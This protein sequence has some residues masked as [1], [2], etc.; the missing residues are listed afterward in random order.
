MCLLKKGSV[1]DGARTRMIAS[2]GL[3]FGTN[4]ARAIVADCSN[5]EELGACVVP[6]P[7]GREG[8]LLHPGDERVARQ[9]PANYLY[10]LEASVRG[11]LREAAKREGF[12]PEFVIGIG[13]AATASSPI[14]VDAEN[15]PLGLLPEWKN[16]LDAQC[17]LW[18]DHSGF[19]EA[20][21]ITRA[22]KE[23]R[24]EYL[25]WCGGAYS[26]EWFW[27]KIW[28][29]ANVAPRVFEAARS[30]VELCDYIPAVL[31]GVRDPA[32]IRRGICA[33]GHK[34]LYG[35]LWGGLPDKAFL[36]VL[37]PRL[38]KLRDRLFEQAFDDSEIAGRLSGEWAARLGLPVGIPLAIGKVD[39]HAGAVGCG[40]S[41]GT[42]VKVIGTSACDCLIV[43][44]AHEARAIPG[45]SGIVKGA[46][47]PGYF[48][49]EA[50]QSAVGD[51]FK[52]WAE[53]ICGGDGTAH[54][55]LTAECAN[56][57]PGE[58]G[59][60]ALD[61]NN[62]NRN[63]LDDPLLS[64]VLIGQTLRTTR[65]EIYRALLEATAFGARTILERLRAYGV[66]PERIICAGG[67]AE[68]NPLLMQIYA[69]VTGCE[70]QVARSGQACALG[71]AIG[72]R[73]AG[74]NCGDGTPDGGRQ[75]SF[76]E[77]QK[78]MVRAPIHSYHPIP[79][80]RVIYERLYSLY[81]DLHD[82]F[83]G[84]RENV[85]VYNTMKSLQALR[86]EVQDN[87]YGSV[88]GPQRDSAVSILS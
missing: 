1:E 57:R 19:E 81:L 68:K 50:G 7:S 9:N 6:Y 84:V 41:E 56:L 14:P 71:A 58:S 13:V 33:A 59:L 42:M 10:A 44:K 3:D 82:A 40:V 78:E 74:G 2:I 34:A 38:A 20:A 80:S 87:A 24:P 4:S 36:A 11:A 5:G 72:G 46:I 64:G 28:H 70:L 23:M 61:W 79:A 35:E 53:T 32:E 49:I 73:V 30:W 15:V 27:A 75:I 67:I 22:A 62:G 8:I 76:E 26:S 77:A 48:G 37:D 51:I 16:D 17:W 12:R 43:P 66:H 54:D 83:G 65:A 47:L 29:C 31:A 63:I 25:A 86:R 18:K 55:E 85:N 21:E 88:N 52:W 45:I 69:D 60:L 39:V